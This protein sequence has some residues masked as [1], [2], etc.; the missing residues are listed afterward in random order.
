MVR[1][2]LLPTRSSTRKVPLSDVFISATLR[3]DNSN[4]NNKCHSKS[5]R[6]TRMCSAHE[7]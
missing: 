4:S 6:Q 7:E 2:A 3:H 1:R 5:K